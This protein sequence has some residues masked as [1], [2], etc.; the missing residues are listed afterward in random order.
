MKL[1]DRIYVMYDGHI[2]YEFKHGE[3]DDHKLG[4][5]MLGGKINE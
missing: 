1:S 4:L 2:N 3:A 5:L